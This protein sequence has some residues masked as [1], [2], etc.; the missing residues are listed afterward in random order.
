MFL[1]QLLLEGIA[2]QLALVFCEAIGKLALFILAAV[3]L[4]ALGLVVA[5]RLFS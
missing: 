4:H 1:G 2:V 5:V 3:L